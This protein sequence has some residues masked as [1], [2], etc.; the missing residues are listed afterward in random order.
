VNEAENAKYLNK[1][2]SL[3]AVAVVAVGLI[4]GVGLIWIG[5]IHGLPKVLNNVLQAVGASVIA[6]LILYVLVSVSIDRRRQKLQDEE[7]VRLQRQ[8]AEESARQQKQQ[9][10]EIVVFGIE[11]ANRQFVKRFEA[12]LPTAVFEGSKHPK[13]NFR[14]AFVALR[15][16]GK[17]PRPRAARDLAAQPTL[18]LVLSTTENHLVGVEQG[19]QGVHAICA[20]NVPGRQSL[21][22]G[23]A[24]TMIRL[25]WSVNQTLGL[26]VCPT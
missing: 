17:G 18:S 9:A 1:Y 16:R 26:D 6:S 13:Q 2:L 20:C 21:A 15:L 22:R 19:A 4:L 11:E 7:A 5:T 3:W 14:K 25:G 24:I 10:E 8:Q 23:H 12:A